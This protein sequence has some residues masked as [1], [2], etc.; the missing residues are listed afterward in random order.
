MENQ[1]ERWIS[2]EVEELSVNSDT[3]GASRTTGDDDVTYNV[4]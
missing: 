2:P 4:S 1:L 3:L